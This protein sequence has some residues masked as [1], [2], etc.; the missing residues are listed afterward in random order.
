MVLPLLR[1]ALG[2]GVSVVS[3]IP[4]VEHRTY[5]LVLVTRAGG[6]RNPKRP[7]KLSVPQL[8]LMVVHHIGLVEAEELYDVVLDALYDAV[9]AQTVVE[10]VGYLHSVRETKG[11]TSIGSPLPDTFAVQGTV[12]VGVRPV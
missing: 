12:L 10:G 3:V 6:V 4:N 8:D 11:A 9:S 2:D 7:R 5:P 1:Q